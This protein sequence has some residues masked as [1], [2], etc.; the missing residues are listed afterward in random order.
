MFQSLELFPHMNAEQNILFPAQ[1]R[2]R[3][4]PETQK[5]ML[6]FTRAFATFF[7]FKKTSVYAFWRRKA[8]GG[9]SQSFDSKASIFD[10]R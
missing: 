8:K 4:K 9:F 2:K 3:D 5:R 6:M 1:A 10:F 7:F